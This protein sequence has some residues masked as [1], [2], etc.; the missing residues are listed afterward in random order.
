MTIFMLLA[1][2]FIALVAGAFALQNAVPVTLAFMK[3]RLEGSLALILLAG[4]GLGAVAGLLVSLPALL[5]SQWRL[6]ALKRELRDKEYP[7]PSNAPG[8]P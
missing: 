3:W 8:R 5:K 1:A 7:A 6:N 4:F 2:L